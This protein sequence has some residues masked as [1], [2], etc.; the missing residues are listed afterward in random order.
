MS[1]FTAPLVVEY[2]DGHDW[3][4]AR[5]FAFASDVLKETVYVPAGFVTDFASIPRGLWNFLPP[6]G[7]YAS[8]AVMHD[9]LYRCTNTD[10]ELCDQVLREG[11]EVLGV[12]WLTRHLIYRAVRIFGGAAR[13][14]MECPN[15]SL[16]KD[17]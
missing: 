1:S 11:M 8:A 17:R 14:K 5:S 15:E 10:R 9:W 2:I 3:R 7:R 4:L 6:T 12:G 16:A 13:K